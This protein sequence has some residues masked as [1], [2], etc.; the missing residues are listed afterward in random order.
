M[1]EHYQHLA[2]A[3]LVE[4]AAEQVAPVLATCE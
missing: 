4:G 1:L 2:D 3:P